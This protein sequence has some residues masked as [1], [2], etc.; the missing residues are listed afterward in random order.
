[1]QLCEELALPHSH[2]HEA[3]V[4]IQGGS[5]VF[6]PTDMSRA[7]TLT[8]PQLTDMIREIQEEASHHF[9]PP[10]VHHR[11]SPSKVPSR[12]RS[13]MLDH[14]MLANIQ[15]ASG[16]EEVA[17]DR[18]VHSSSSMQDR[19]RPHPAASLSQLMTEEARQSGASASQPHQRIILLRGPRVKIGIDEGLA[20]AELSPVTGRMIY[21]GKFMNRAARISAKAPSGTC[22]CSEGAWEGAKE[23]AT[24]ELISSLGLVGDRLGPFQ[25]KGV[26]EEVNL[27]QCSFSRAPVSIFA[28]MAEAQTLKMPQMIQGSYYKPPS[29]IIPPRAANLAPPV[30]KI[31]VQEIPESASAKTRRPVK[32]AATR[33]SLLPDLDRISPQP[34]LQLSKRQHSLGM[35]VAFE[36]DSYYN[37]LDPDPT[38]NN[39]PGVKYMQVMN[40]IERGHSSSLRSKEGKE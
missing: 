17:G 4:S 39:N 27:F 15:S 14:H 25:L 3:A 5:K 31:E 7:Q 35:V 40:E 8:G 29:L 19:P 23:Q 21:R 37:S 1:M 33:M 11:A 6:T 16:L 9:V 28:R 32:R 22:W 20:A 26:Q 13:G 24:A 38:V 34:A 10:S 12:N 36:P 2:S 18:L 30:V